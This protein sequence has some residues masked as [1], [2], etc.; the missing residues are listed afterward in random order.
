MGPAIPARLATKDNQQLVALIHNG[1]PARGMLPSSLKDPEVVNLVRFSGG[2][3][4]RPERV[5]VRRTVQTD[6]GVT[7]RARFSARVPTT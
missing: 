1:L 2:L 7:S 3:Q 4:R 6:S 5:T